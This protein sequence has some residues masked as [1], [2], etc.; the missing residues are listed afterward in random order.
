MVATLK[1]DK[2]G[3][4]VSDCRDTLNCNLCKAGVGKR[5]FLLII[6]VKSY[7]STSKTINKAS[8]LLFNATCIDNI[9]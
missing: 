5:Y 4:T 1:L 2:E 7:F 3:Y 9:D 6:C 8:M